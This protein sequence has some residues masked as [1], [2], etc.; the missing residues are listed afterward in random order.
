MLSISSFL[1]IDDNIHQSFRLSDVG[2]DTI[3][4]STNITRDIS[5]V[6]SIDKAIILYFIIGEK[7]TTHICVLCRIIENTYTLRIERWNYTE[8]F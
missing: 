8:D 7:N 2:I 1:V 6:I 5:Q 4:T 3:D